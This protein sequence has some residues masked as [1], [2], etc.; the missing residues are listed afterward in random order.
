MEVLAKT[1]GMSHEAW[2]L[3]RSKGIGGSDAGVICG[4]NPWKSKLELYL[5]KIGEIPP[6]EENE[7]MYWG[8]VLEDVV[9]QEFSKRTGLKVQRKNSIIRSTEFPFML[10]NIDRKIVGIR[11]GLECKTANAFTK[12]KWDDG[13]I[14]DSYIAQIQHYMSVT[15]F[16]AWWVAVLIG[17]NEFRYQRV[18][19]DKEFIEMLIHLESDFWNN[20]VLAGVMP[21]PDGSSACRDVIK[22]MFP[23]S[24]PETQKSLTGF[25]DDLVRDWFEYQELEKKY[26][27][28]KEETANK[29]KLEL[30]NHEKGFTPKNIIQWKSIKS[31]KFD[32]KS[33]QKDHPDLFKKYTKESSY[34]RFSIKPIDK[35][36]M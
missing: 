7:F 2:L 20:N 17:G 16:E 32:S 19:R 5:D 9:A 26:A 28:L 33:F 1:H 25:H 10:A 4:L 21:E 29:I 34:R 12:S 14:P 15:C 11:E 27:D 23:D 35:G 36:E 13:K 18:E 22:K 30:E 24:V 8:N 31:D 3:Q 6:V